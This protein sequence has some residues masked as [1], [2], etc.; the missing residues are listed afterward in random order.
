MFFPSKQQ[1]T[2][3][4]KSLAILFF[5]FFGNDCHL[6]AN[7]C[8]CCECGWCCFCSILFA[9][10]LANIE[11]V[12]FCILYYS[13][14]PLI[15]FHGWNIL[16]FFFFL[17]STYITHTHSHESLCSFKRSYLISVCF[18]FCCC[19]FFSVALICKQNH[20]I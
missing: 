8:Y 9:Q 13:L 20:P 10:Y 1:K 19:C 5:F 11:Y 6:I 17:S 3:W 16:L 18:F 7:G 12:F 2:E 14:P 15:W 4:N